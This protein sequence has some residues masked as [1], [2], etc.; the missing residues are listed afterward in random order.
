MR[1]VMRLLRR[2]LQ[3]PR[4]RIVLV[5]TLILLILPLIAR[6]PFFI[7]TLMLVYMYSIIALAWNLMNGYTGLLSFGHAIYFGLGAYTLML[8]L[9]RDITPWL[10]MLVGGLLAGGVA[11]AIGVP[12]S[13]L[14][15]HWFAL[16][17]LV[18]GEI[19]QLVFANW[20]TVGGALG[21]DLPRHLLLATPSPY[22]INY[23]K[24]TPYYYLALGILGLEL[25][26]L[27]AVLHSKPGYFMQAIRE[28]EEAARASGVNVTFYRCISMGL[29]GLFT[30]IAGGIYTL[31]FAYI[32]PYAVFSLMRISVYPVIAGL[33]GGVYS[34][35]GPVVGS[36]IFIPTAEYLR[37]IIGGRWGA[38]FH[39]LHF[40]S[41][42]VVLLLISMRIPEGM[43]GW[44]EMRG[45]LKALG[46][47]E[48]GEG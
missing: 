6:D 9:Y 15:S 27:Y 40:A 16:G 41:F 45:V 38:R 33:I 20:E 24:P 37:V 5:A 28:D 25:L 19:F 30:G 34:L 35:I 14:R 1:R 2:E 21:L 7:N 23:P 10:G 48:G 22:W 44:L 47:S 32:D 12:L 31:R 8:L 43:M 13:R 18:L 17:T 4:G 11:F 26:T 39:G 42:G 36:L 3:T 29:S 46:R